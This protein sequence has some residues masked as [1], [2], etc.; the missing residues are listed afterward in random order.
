M[1]M[2]VRKVKPVLKEEEVELDLVEDEPT[3][4]PPK[5]PLEQHC[6]GQCKHKKSFHVVKI[7]RQAGGYDYACAKV[8]C[9]CML[10]VPGHEE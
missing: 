7:A 3:P 6:G 4:T 9:P 2:A 1:E 10:Y 8:D 5:R